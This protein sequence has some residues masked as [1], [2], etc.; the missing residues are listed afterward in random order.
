MAAND[1]KEINWLKLDFDAVA[2]RL[3]QRVKKAGEMCG[4]IPED[5][6]DDEKLP[7]ATEYD[8]ALEDFEFFF[9]IFSRAVGKDVSMKRQM[10]NV[11]TDIGVAAPTDWST[12]DIDSIKVSLREETAKFEKN[13]DDCVDDLSE[14]E[15]AAAQQLYA[16]VKNNYV[17]FMLELEPY[18]RKRIKLEKQTIELLERL[19]PGK[20]IIWSELDVNDIK[21]RVNDRLS[22]VTDAIAEFERTHIMEGDDI[23]EGAI[24]LGAEYESAF[25]DSLF[26]GAEFMATLW[27][28]IQSKRQ[29]AEIL[30]NH[31]PDLIPQ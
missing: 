3:E 24:E 12:L 20:T 25:N 16:T 6:S 29:M 18:F 26:F 10:L 21:I 9:R 22:K 13:V 27:N 23:P 19:N 14:E 30:R 1:K 5:A 2:E 17:A 28:E 11:L 31:M 15:A 4:N 8:N 7:A